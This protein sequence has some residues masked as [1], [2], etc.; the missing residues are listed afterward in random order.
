MT[1]QPTAAVTLRPAKEGDRV[2]LR[3]LHHAAMREV[4]EQIWGWDEAEQDRYFDRAF[5]IEKV[6]IVRLDSDDVGAIRIDSFEDCLFLADIEIEPA[7]QGQGIGTRLIL[8]LQN[9]AGGL[10][11]PVTLQVLKS[12]RARQLYERL[13][14]VVTG[15]TETHYRMRWR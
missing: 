2:W 10:G 1:R 4:V 5:D 15:E 12:N 14:F 8:E 7:Y 6:R 3:A 11:L 9:E 13:G